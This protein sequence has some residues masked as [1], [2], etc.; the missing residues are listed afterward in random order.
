MTLVYE[1]FIQ[2][3]VGKHPV[4]MILT[5]FFLAVSNTSG[6][7]PETIRFNPV[8]ADSSVFKKTLDGTNWIPFAL[9][10]PSRYF[11]I[12]FREDAGMPN[13]R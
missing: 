8:L 11:S 7:I 4:G 12:P 3:P 9:H 13:C 1:G 2:C 5:G 10:V 6:V